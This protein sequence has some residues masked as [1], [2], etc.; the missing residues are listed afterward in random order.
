MVESY[1][2]SNSQSTKTI[3]SSLSPLPQQPL[4]SLQYHPHHCH[5]QSVHQHSPPS[6]VV[7][8]WNPP[9]EPVSTAQSDNTVPPNSVSLAQTLAQ[10]HSLPQSPFHHPHSHRQLK[11]LP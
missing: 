4:H 1:P 6:P 8:A 2:L 3:L 10:S 9:C 7:V 5:S 11:P